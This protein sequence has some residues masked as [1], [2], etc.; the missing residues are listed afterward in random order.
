[1]KAC[2]L[3][4]SRLRQEIPLADFIRLTPLQ[5]RAICEVCSA[6]F[7]ALNLL[8]TCSSCGRRR[9][10]DMSDPC[11]DCLRWEKNGQFKFINSA[12][13]EYNPAMKD[14]MKRY[15]FAG[16]YR[17]R[18]V[19]SDQIHEQLKKQ[20]AIIV[21]I[22]VGKDTMTTWGFN[23][24]TGLLE[25]DRYLN[26]LSVR[27]DKKAVRQSAKNRQGRLLLDQPF[28][29]IESQKNQVKNQAVL[30]V[31]DVY[32][33]GTTIR[34]AAALIQQAGATSVKGFTLAR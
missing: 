28:E 7:S 16:D 3:C 14:Y 20:S 25:N 9:T 23:Q 6:T 4:G 24:V 5:K 2:L 22:P 1:M 32:T 13:Y 18:K 8:P 27:F 15:K 31:D 34:H 17:L 21:Q 19:F 26:L 33:T 11:Y 29:M 10:T 12:V 30:L